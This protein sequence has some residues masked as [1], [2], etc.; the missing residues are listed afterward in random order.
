MEFKS[1]GEVTGIK[2]KPEYSF[3]I[4]TG[5]YVISKKCLPL[6]PPGK[7]FHMTDL[8]AEI[9]HKQGKVFMY[10]VNEK[11]YVDIGQWEEYQKVMDTF[12]KN[13]QRV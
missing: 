12:Y 5:F 7:M 1:G 11:E 2:E 4:N 10:P 13:G 6:I 9:I 8:I 3:P